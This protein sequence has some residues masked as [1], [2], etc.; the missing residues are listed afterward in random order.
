MT[1]HQT[2]HPHNLPL[3]V[4]LPPSEMYTGRGRTQK[5]KMALWIELIG[6]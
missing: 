6:E 4:P 5:L 1:M 3:P 2:A